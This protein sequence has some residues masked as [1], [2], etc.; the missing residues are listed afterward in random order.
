MKTVSHLHYNI[1]PNTRLGD[2]DH[3]DTKHIILSDTEVTAVLKRMKALIKA[4][5][6]NVCYN[7]P[8]RKA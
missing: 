4:P 2:I 1:I 5:T 6:H 7:G 3:E 8:S